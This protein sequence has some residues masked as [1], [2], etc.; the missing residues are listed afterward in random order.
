MRPH[1]CKEDLI[2]IKQLRKEKKWGAKRLCKEFPRKGWCV[3][4][5]N[6]I[7]NKVDNNNDISRKT[8]SGRP[9]S[10]RTPANIAETN[11]LV[12]SQNSQPGTHKSQREIALQ[13]G[14]AQSSVHGII[15]K[16]LN[17]SCFRKFNVEGLTEGEMQRRV[18][19][20]KILLER[21]P[22]DAALRR[23]RVWFSDE[24]VFTINQ[25]VNKRND[26]VYS[27]RSDER[28]RDVSPARIEVTTRAHG[29]RIMVGACVGHA[30]KTELVFFESSVRLDQNKYREVLEEHYF[31]DIRAYCG[32]RWTFQQ[33]GATCHTARSVRDF[34]ENACPQHIEPEAWPPKSPDLNPMDFFVWGELQRLVYRGVKIRDLDHLRERLQVCWAKISQRQVIKAIEAFPKRLEACIACGGGRFEHR[35]DFE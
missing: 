13:L 14:L 19:R 29:G 24:S 5:V 15:H 35:L 21:Y 18:E 30:G 31:P 25:K 32:D 23:A 8:G 34:L 12:L 22:T 6:R 28:R 4:T 20:A 26:R 7:L 33:D 16:D 9:R 27:R 11:D 17:L 10:A 1:V 3:R 2:L